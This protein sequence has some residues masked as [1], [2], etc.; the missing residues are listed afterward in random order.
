M[1]DTVLMI[2]SLLTIVLT[3]ISFSTGMR[4]VFSA[5]VERDLSRT[6]QPA[7]NPK[8][9]LRRRPL[10]GGALPLSG[11]VLFGIAASLAWNVITL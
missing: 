4:H 1:S 7:D 10:I 8:L 6:G 2:A 5:K 11:L 9:N 3:V